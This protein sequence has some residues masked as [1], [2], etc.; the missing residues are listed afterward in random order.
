MASSFFFNL[1]SGLISQVVFRRFKE[2]QQTAF[3][4]FEVLW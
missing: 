1:L 2:V 4:F 3:D